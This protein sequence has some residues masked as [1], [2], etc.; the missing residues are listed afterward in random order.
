EKY[1]FNNVAELP[2]YVNKDKIN[3][4]L[5]VTFDGIHILNGDIVSPQSEIVIELTDENQYLALDDTSDYEVY[6][7][8]PGVVE[9]R[10]Y[11]NQ[12][13]QNKM[14]FIPASLPKNKSRII[15][16]GNF[17]VDGDYKLRV[18]ANDKSSNQSGIYD[19]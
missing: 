17:P 19:Y 10:I 13:G 11:F 6:I 1:H 14:T 15:Y 2:F 9:K 16:P 18:R 4:I 8:S 12:S 7:T 5:D 3:P